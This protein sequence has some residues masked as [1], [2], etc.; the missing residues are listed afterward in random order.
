MNAALKVVLERREKDKAEL[1]EK[2][3][4]NTKELVLPY[5]ATLKK[6]RLDTQ[7]TALVGIIESDVKEM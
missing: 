7:Q 1:E 5:L 2:V 3:V 4:S 6:T